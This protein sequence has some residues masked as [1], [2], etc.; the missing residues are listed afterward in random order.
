MMKKLHFLLFA[1]FVSFI[2]PAFCQEKTE[3]EINQ[4]IE[5]LTLEEKIRM[6]HAQ[7]KFSSAGVPRLG[8]PELWMSDGPHGVRAEIDWDSWNHAGWTNDSCTAFPALTCLASTFNPALAYKYG[9]A[10]GEE[11]RY[12]EKDILLG[13]GVNIYRTPLNGRNFEYMG[14]DPYLASIM[15]VPYIQ[16]VQTNGVAACVKHYALNNQEVW[17]GHIDVQVSD[18]ALYEIY[19]PAF[20]AAVE[21]GKVW[22]LMGSY[23]KYDGQWC[24]HNEVLMNDILKGDWAY[25]GVVMTDWGSAHDTKEAALYGLDLEMGTGTNGLTF[26]TKNAY[27][28]YFM[29]LPL[30]EMVKKG[31]I[32]E[33]F[34]DDKVRRLLRLMYRTSLSG[35]SNMGSKGSQAHFD[36]AREIAEEGIVL[37]QNKKEFLPISKT[38]T[39]TIAVIGENATKMMTLGGG[40]SELKALHEISPL[41]GIEKE[42]PQ[43]NIIHAMGYSTGPSVYDRVVDSPLNQDSLRTAAVEAAKQ[44]DIVLYVGGLNKNHEQDCEGI[45]RKIYELPFG[46]EAL[47]DDIFAVNKNVAVVLVSG[48]AVSTPWKKSTQAIVQAWYLGSET[49]TAIANVLSGDVNPSG[50]LPFSFP[51]KLEDNG[52]HAFDHMTYPGDDVTVEYTEDILVGY[53]WHDTKKIKPAFA[54]GH[55]L[56]YTEFDFTSA[57]VNKSSLSANDVV[58]LTVELKNSGNRDGSEVVQVYVHDKKASVMRPVK[59]LKAFQKL[60]LKAGE[61]K[62]VTLEVPVNSFAFYDEAKKDW[63]LEAGEYVLMIGS[64]SDKIEKKVTLTVE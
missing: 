2:T 37:L 51:E 36:V 17:R 44:A 16:G 32:E 20:Q 10:V 11:A 45:D 14:E 15:C 5:Q 43:A 62:S 60:S 3:K 58:E 13:P 33:K 28:N 49:G 8:I 59:E 35:N 6:I 25:D 27:E 50:K 48:N 40:S 23:N 52:A 53:R 57:S 30:Q 39:Q 29:A 1:L 24:S 26:S 31:E 22:A 38:T 46:Q 54:F 41:E 64:A 47:L 34:I 18:R 4:I 63:N 19:L 55:G 12:R 21:Q 7:S 9:V 42:F 61:T 56:S